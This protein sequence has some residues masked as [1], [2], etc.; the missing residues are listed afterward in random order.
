M[1]NLWNSKITGFWKQAVPAATGFISVVSALRLRI[2]K[3]AAC[4][5]AA[6]YHTL[7]RPFLRS[8]FNFI[9]RHSAPVYYFFALL[10]PVRKK[11]LF[12]ALMS[13]RGDAFLAPLIRAARQ[14]GCFDVVVLETG[15]GIP[16][17]FKLMY[18]LARS[19]VIVLDSHYRYLY[20]VSP[21][22]ETI[23]IQAWHAA[24]LFKKFGLGLCDPGDRAALREQVREHSAYSHFLTSS[25]ALNEAYAEAFG[26]R[27]EQAL[28]LGAVKTDALYRAKENASAHRKA[29]DAEFPQAR[30]KKLV[31]YAPT[32]RNE[33]FSRLRGN[34]T[35]KLPVRLDVGAFSDRFGATHCL[36]FRAHYRHKNAYAQEP[37]YINVT[38]YSLPRLLASAD[39][40]I[41]DYSSIIFDFSFFARPMIFFAYDLDTY[42]ASRGFYVPFAKFAPGPVCRTSEEVL[43]A[44]GNASPFHASGYAA[45]H[46]QYLSACDG[47]VCDK[48]MAFLKT[49]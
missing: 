22:K 40:L 43:L 9:A 48:I 30:G 20:G 26:K 25:P 33:D 2:F 39:I 34:A 6:F 32:F 28:P 24:G 8:V 35:E 41:T 14:D 38:D 37:G 5:S 36:A 10:F 17:Y 42:H 1:L 12:F 16:R 18:T 44:V 21:R 46:E 27:P 31:L 49:R 11:Q 23:V 3:A 29:F 45:F 4:R 19:R 47:R 13:E 7:Y 15:P